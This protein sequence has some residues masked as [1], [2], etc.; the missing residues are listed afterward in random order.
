MANNSETNSVTG[1]TIGFVV[2]LIVIFGL[3]KLVG[4]LE[5]MSFAPAPSSPSKFERLASSE[6]GTTVSRIHD[7]E[8]N[9]LILLLLL[10]FFFLRTHLLSSFPLFLLFFFIIPCSVEMTEDVPRKRT[11]TYPTGTSPEDMLEDGDTSFESADDW[12]E[13]PVHRASIAIA[14][15]AH[16][17]HIKEHLLELVSTV[18]SMEDKSNELLEVNVVLFL[19]IVVHVN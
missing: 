12:E 11:F 14:A 10:G 7:S 6:H 1:I 9:L 16:R 4:Y 17:D 2:G 15:P 19:L 5:N 13:E 18:R 3:E 8:N